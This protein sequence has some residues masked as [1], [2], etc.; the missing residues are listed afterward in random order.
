[1]QVQWLRTANERL[2]AR[3]VPAG[4]PA[5]PDSNNSN[6]PPSSDGLRKGTWTTSW[7]CSARSSTSAH[8]CWH[9]P[10]HD[11]TGEPVGRRP[12][13]HQPQ[14]QTPP[15]PR[16]AR[17]G[18]RLGRANVI[19]QLDQPSVASPAASCA[20]HRSSSSH[21]DLNRYVQTTSPSG[22]QITQ[23]GLPVGDAGLFVA[24]VRATERE[25][26]PR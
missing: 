26:I 5:G 1:V 4:R 17:N 11:H 20:A 23:Y 21:Y 19:V 6:R 9:G 10:L 2:Q 22:E 12:G 15:P 7:P 3:V 14:R 25:R 13:L 18:D 8:H 24:W 16:P